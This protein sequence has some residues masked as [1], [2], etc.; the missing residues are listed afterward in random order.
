MGGWLGGWLGGWPVKME[1][2][3]NSASAEVEAG[4]GAEL[5]KNIIMKQRWKKKLPCDVQDF[6][7]FYTRKAGLLQTTQS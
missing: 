7:T 1:I 4:A 5:G 3:L 2:M 6:V